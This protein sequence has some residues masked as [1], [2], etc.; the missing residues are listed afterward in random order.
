MRS[1]T[2]LNAVLLIV[3]G[4][5]G[6]AAASIVAQ[7]IQGATQGNERHIPV[8]VKQLPLDGGTF[9]VELR[10]A[11]ARVSAQNRLE[12][13]TCL[14]INN[15]NKNISAL[16]ATYTVTIA[17]G[18][19][20][21]ADEGVLTLD[22]FIHPDVREAR[23]LKLISPSESRTLQPPGPITYEDA[24]V[25]GVGVQ[26]DYVEF[27][28]KTSTGPN[29]HGSTIINSMREGAA[30]YKVWLIQQYARGQGSDAS[31]VSLLE[32]PEIPETLHADGNEHLIE[33]ARI[34]QRVMRN[35][36]NTQGAAELKR[37]LNR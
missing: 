4:A 31:I 10:C 33:G 13:F 14:A 9:P 17:Q 18:G 28:D 36:Y 35:V 2:L 22:S 15:T 8:V 32:S 29:K 27:A 34:Y 21:S 23:R 19:S 25:K 12:G 20:E 24:V 30:K 6:V 11:D 7:S 3:L 16:S 5:L 1:K 26:V 37:F